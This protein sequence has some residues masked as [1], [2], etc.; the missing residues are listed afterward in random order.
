MALAWGDSWGTSWGQSWLLYSPPAS[1]NVIPGASL[2]FEVAGQ[3][4][5]IYADSALQA[6]LPNPVYADA[7]GLFPAIYLETDVVYTVTGAN[8][9][10]FT[11]LYPPHTAYLTVADGIGAGGYAVTGYSQP[12]LFNF[13]E[14]EPTQTIADGVEVGFMWDRLDTFVVG[15]TGVNAVEGLSLT[16]MIN[17]KTYVTTEAFFQIAGGQWPCNAWIWFG[18]EADFVD[19][20]TYPLDVTA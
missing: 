18:Q 3:P 11:Q 9:W 6:A 15:L 5:A 16:I 14:M 1:G 2:Y 17:G 4:A 20:E 8:G 10:S 7:G 19:G 12:D 13:G